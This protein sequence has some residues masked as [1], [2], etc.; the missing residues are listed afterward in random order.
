MPKSRTYPNAEGTHTHLEHP[1]MP[2]QG[3]WCPVG[4]ADT[5]VEARGWKHTPPPDT[6]LDGLFDTSTAEG[7]NQ[8]GFDPAEHDVPD[9]NAHLEEM[10]A[11][12]ADGEVNRVLELE[13]AGKNRKTVVDPREPV[14]P[15]DDPDPTD[16][17]T[18]E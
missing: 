1:E 7:A 13:R 3:W 14:D 12:G 9:V 2:G 18:G 8:T 15:D 6:S 16:G 11:A 10:H 17:N 5:F 4:V